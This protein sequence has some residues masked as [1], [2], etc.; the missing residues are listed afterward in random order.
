MKE[1]QIKKNR[2]IGSSPLFGAADG[3]DEN[4]GM[5]EKICNGH[6]HPILFRKKSHSKSGVCFEFLLDPR[7]YGF[8][9]RK[10][11]QIEILWTEHC[12]GL[13]SLKRES[14]VWF[15]FGGGSE[16]IS[17]RGEKN[18]P[19]LG[20]QIY[21]TSPQKQP[22]AKTHWRSRYKRAKGREIRKG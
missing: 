11:L 18:A 10:L 12:K 1:R 7:G 21:Q 9:F 14:G 22:I 3:V 19:N 20:P 5:W 15:F 6:T 4:R 2:E 17:W 13:Q 8:G 16:W